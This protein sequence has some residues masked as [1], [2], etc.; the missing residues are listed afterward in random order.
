MNKDTYRPQKITVALIRRL[1][2][3]PPPDSL[4]EVRDRGAKLTLRH[5]PKTSR[6]ILYVELG[7]GKREKLCDARDVIDPN[8]ALM[9]GQVQ[10]RARVLRGDDAGGRDFKEERGATRAVP[11]LSTYLDEE[12][13]GSYGEWVIENRKD[14]AATLAR[15]KSCFLDTFGKRKIDTITPDVMDAWRTKRRRTVIAETINR[16]TNSIKSALSKA[17]E[18]NKFPVSPLQGYKLLQTDRH[19]RSLRALTDDEVTALRAALKARDQRIRQGRDSGNQWREERGHK[20]MPGLDGAFTDALHPAVLISLATGMR[21]NELF[22]LTWDKVDLRSKVIHLEGANTK[23]FLSRDLPLNPEAANTLRQWK[24]QQG[25]SPSGYVFPSGS[26]HIADLKKSFYKVIDDAGIERETAQGRATWHS[27][28]HTFGTRLGAAGV[29]P[30]TLRELMGH[31]NLTTTQ[32]YLQT[33]AG[34]KRD[35][36]ARLL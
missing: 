2:K 20:Q 10:E 12:K 29:D 5:H 27:L 33:D 22:T 8:H 15:L 3:L 6:M 17:V 36:V 18:W 28:R 19:K 30:Q 4:R 14:G 21:R 31:A 25:R 23:S 9:M 26:G 1:A 34:R 24:L 7:R 16:D 35:A 13:A 11:T 32:R